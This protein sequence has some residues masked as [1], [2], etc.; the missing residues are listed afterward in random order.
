MGREGCTWTPTA[1]DNEALPINCVEPIQAMAF[2]WWD[3]KQLMNEVAYEYLATNRGTTETSFGSSTISA[4]LCD[5]ADIGA[6]AEGTS[7]GS[8]L[9]PRRV[10]PLAFDARPRDVT[11]DPAGVFNLFGGVRE[12][13]FTTVPLPPGFYAG[14]DPD[15]CST[16]F[17]RLVVEADGRWVPDGVWL[18]FEEYSPRSHVTRGVAWSDNRPML[19]NWRFAT[20]RPRPFEH[21]SSGV[22]RGFRCHRWERP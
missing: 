16:L 13:L 21:Q 7:P 19:E 3:G 6:L 12:W 14:M 8:T 2:C 22:D 4:S 11:R 17:P 18:R 1:G 5:V 20:S 9:C 15:V 10:L